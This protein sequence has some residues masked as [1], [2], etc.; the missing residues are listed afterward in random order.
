MVGAVRAA[1]LLAPLMPHETKI[2]ADPARPRDTILAAIVKA[3]HG[4]PPEPALWQRGEAG[5]LL[6][7]RALAEEEVSDAMEEAGVMDRV[8]SILRKSEMQYT[9]R[10]FSRTFAARIE[11]RGEAI[12][13]TRLRAILDR[14]IAEGALLATEERYP[15]IKLPPHVA[16]EPSTDWLAGVDNQ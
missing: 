13:E 9:A 8:R 5:A 4:R 6:F 15:K 1:L 7:H 16:D 12:S 2:A 11:W 14:A 10:E 3:N